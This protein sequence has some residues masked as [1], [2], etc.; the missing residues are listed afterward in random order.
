[1]IVLAL[2][3]Y[4]PRQVLMIVFKKFQIRL[5]LQALSPRSR[6]KTVTKIP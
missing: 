6:I 2:A 1:M 4:Q 5:L 3:R